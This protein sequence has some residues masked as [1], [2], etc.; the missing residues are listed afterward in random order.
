VITLQAPRQ[1]SILRFSPCGRW[2]FGAG[3]DAKVYRWDASQ[4]E[5]TAVAPLEG[6]QG[7][8]TALAVTNRNARGNESSEK[9]SR[10]FT[11]D[12]WGQLRCWPYAAEK[13]EPLWSIPAAHDGWIRQIAVNPDGQTLATCG[14]DGLVVLW[15]AAD[16]QKLQA[17]GDRGTDVF[18][19]AFHPDGKS[20]V[21]GD[22]QGTI[23][24]W[25]LA[26]GKVVR[27]FD[28][29]AMHLLSDLQDVGGVRRLVFDGT[30]K[31]LAACGARPQSGGFV[32][33]TPLVR[34]FDWESGK[35]IETH[36]FGVEKDGFVHDL[37]AHPAGYWLGVTSGQPGN[38]KFF[39]WRAGEKQPFFEWT[40]LA[41]CHSIA[42]HADGVR[43]A[44]A[45][46]NAGSNGN[47][48]MKKSDE[49]YQG[50]WSPVSLWDLT[51]LTP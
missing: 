17:W 19:V 15:S 34:L 7:W 4:A 24:H 35:E 50:N 21:S 32:Q 22:L 29:K 26:T 1:L 27:Q 2:L 49:A 23:H 25:D 38:G 43:I 41:N 14:V 31:T 5:L 46:T 51:T 33:A 9:D 20:L 42:L 36:Q 30:G 47:G 18:S 13:P 8:V 37:A 45:S 12:S 39:L 44:V 11:A 48:R 16:G 28:A 10:L 3:C 40:K 6:H